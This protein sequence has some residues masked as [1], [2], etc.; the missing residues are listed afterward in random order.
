MLSKC[1]PLKRC[2]SIP[3]HFTLEYLRLNVCAQLAKVMQLLHFNY[4]LAK[5]GVS[6]RR[7]SLVTLIA[8]SHNSALVQIAAAAD[9]PMKAPVKAPVMATDWTGFYIGGNFGGI[10]GHG[11]SQDA[12]SLFPPGTLGGIAPGVVN[13]VSSASG[14]GPTGAL[15]GGQI[16]YN[17]QIGRW[18]LGAEGDFDW[19]GAKSGVQYQNFLASSVVV[20]PARLLYSDDE[21][22]KWLATARLRLGWSTDSFLWYITGGGAWGGVDTSYTFQ[23]TGS[24]TFATNPA[25][26]SASTTKFG[27]A[28]GG[29]VETT[30]GW[31]G[32]SN[33]W[34]AKLEYLYVD[35][36]NVTNTF[37]APLAS[38][39]TS[40]Y[41]VSNDIRIQ[42]HLVRAGLNYRFGGGPERAYASAASSYASA[43]VRLVRILTPARI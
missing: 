30:L 7:I 11:H 21:K 5:W 3:Q 17:W 4:Q 9:I 34:S 8:V 37:T 43:G 32:A 2:C 6:M 25:A 41:T 26:F 31:L 40:A 39:T 42:E 38:T 14:A 35:L 24:P 12:I 36:G 18:V 29:G 13:P 16:G 20:A 19:A 1:E 33:H 27:W 23:G 15:G 22:L 10:I 28:L